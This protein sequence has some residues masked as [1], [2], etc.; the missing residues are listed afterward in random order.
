MHRISTNKL[1]EW[2]I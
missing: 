2:E 1:R